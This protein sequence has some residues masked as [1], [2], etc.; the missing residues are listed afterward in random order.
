[1]QNIGQNKQFSLDLTY[2]ISLLSWVQRNL[3]KWVFRSGI[4]MRGLIII[5]FSLAVF[6]EI[7]LAYKAKEYIQLAMNICLLGMYL[8]IEIVS[9]FVAITVGISRRQIEQISRYWIYGFWLVTGLIFLYNSLKI[10]QIS[11]TFLRKGEE[12]FWA[13]FLPFMLVNILS[14]AIFELLPFLI[15]G[16]A[17]QLP[18]TLFDPQ[19]NDN[20]TASGAEM[21]AERAES[22]TGKIYIDHTPTFKD[23]TG[24]E[25]YQRYGNLIPFFKE[26]NQELANTPSWREL[27]KRVGRENDNGKFCK[28]LYE[29]W[30][31]LQTTA[32]RKNLFDAQGNIIGLEEK[33]I[34]NGVKLR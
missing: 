10:W 12:D 2:V 32:E 17:D 31:T 15:Q 3:F 33:I 9:G 16:L 4:A 24:Q 23:I 6:Y 22:A 34:I 30:K 25:F 8:S 26:K 29:H 20:A 19:G 7:R 1:M 18:P 14:F 21:G 27:D 5:T 11:E 13:L 28:T